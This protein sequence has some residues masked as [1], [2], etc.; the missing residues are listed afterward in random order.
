M[1]SQ[2]LNN[3]AEIL[4]PTQISSYLLATRM[5]ASDIDLLT[6]KVFASAVNQDGLK[7]VSMRRLRTICSAVNAGNDIWEEDNKYHFLADPN[8]TDEC[9]LALMIKFVDSPKFEVL[10]SQQLS[11]D[12][13]R[14]VTASVNAAISQGKSPSTVEWMINPN[15]TSGDL[16]Q[17]STVME[18]IPMS[19]IDVVIEYADLAEFKNAGYEPIGLVEDTDISYLVSAYDKIPAVYGTFAWNTVFTPRTCRVPGFCVGFFKAIEMGVPQLFTDNV[20][21]PELAVELFNWTKEG[22][23]DASTVLWNI[24]RS[25]S[26]SELDLFDPVKVLAAYR[27]FRVAAGKAGLPT[28]AGLYTYHNIQLIEELSVAYCKHLLRPMDFLS[29]LTMEAVDKLLQDSAEGKAASLKSAQIGVTPDHQ[30]KHFSFSYSECDFSGWDAAQ[31]HS[32]KSIIERILVLQN[33]PCTSDTPVIDVSTDFIYNYTVPK[34]IDSELETELSL[35]PEDFS[36]RAIL[37]SVIHQNLEDLVP[38]IKIYY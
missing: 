6:S 26:D 33:Y 5:N 27:K 38:R 11:E 13:V 14:V 32:I 22:F 18:I 15:L 20:D 7:N 2:S 4:T 35:S 21:F 3:A 36:G 37:I 10:K 1:E 25:G 31:V 12:Q 23:T 9:L 16:L 19:A 29:Y 17:I 34:H 8:I 28:P 30:Y 24:Q